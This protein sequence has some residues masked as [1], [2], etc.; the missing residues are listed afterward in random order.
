VY[1]AST[2]KELT[3][4]RGFSKPHLGAFFASQKTGLCG[5]SGRK[6]ASTGGM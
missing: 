6:S 5:G 3:D 2:Q 1:S 4:A